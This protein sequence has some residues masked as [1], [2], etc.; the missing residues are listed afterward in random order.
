MKIMMLSGTTGAKA[1]QL[2]Q[3]LTALCRENQMAVE[4]VTANLYKDAL[5]AREEK[6]KPAA[7]LVVGTN[8]I[9]AGSPTIAGL[10]LLYPWMGTDKMVEEIKHYY[11]LTI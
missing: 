10:S 2:A 6:E 4:V 3:K 1:E 7:I 8:K 9:T 5:P 11:H